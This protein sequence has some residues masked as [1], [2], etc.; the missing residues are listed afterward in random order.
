[1]PSQGSQARLFT[2]LLDRYGPE[3]AK[4]FM[5][6]MSDVRS[7]VQINRVIRAL[8]R[9]DI[10][11]ALEALD[12]ELSV[13]EDL[14]DALQRAYLEGGRTTEGA[15]PRRAGVSFRFSLLGNPRA[16]RWI[17]DH[18]SNLIT[19]INDD[20]RQAVRST[21]REALAQGVNPRSTAIRIVGAVDPR[22]GRREGGV[23][24]LTAA[25]ERYVASARGE[26]ASGETADLRAYL[27]RELRDRRFDRS[28]AKAI[29]DGEPLP[30][31]IQ[32][33]AVL[34]YERR[35]LKFRG[36]MIGRTESLTALNAGQY[37]A[38]RQMVESGKIQAN[39]IRRVWRSAGD[40][41]VRDT[42]RGMNGDSVGLEEA[43]RSPSGAMLLYPG[44]T[45]RGAPASEI[46][47]CRCVAE[48]R[49]DFLANLR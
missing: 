31:D 33:K 19:R 27:G 35:L 9:A 3:I 17:G 45:S 47:N 48:A 16:E 21:L 22:T 1:M 32:R 20:T 2:E 18:S 6:A 12:L 40:F 36:D 38:L 30:A 8:E 7:S 37:E 13:Y 34:A 25:Q 44:D 23:L 42:H 11:A 26:L 46:I 41:R 39:Q 4:A 24:G 28:I 29:R 10:E 49:I 14:R 15:I 43:F 5:R